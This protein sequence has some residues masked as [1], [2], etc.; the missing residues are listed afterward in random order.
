MTTTPSALPGPARAKLEA[1]QAASATPPGDGTTPP[2]D[3][4]TPPVAT[5]PGDGTAPPAGERVTISREEFNALQAN[6]AR[7]QTADAR[8]A[9]TQSRL[10]ELTQRL[11][12]LETSGKPPGNATAPAPAAPAA[13]ATP[14]PAKFNVPDTAGIQFTDEENEQYGEGR[15]YIERVA[16]VVVLDELKKLLPDIESHME[17]LRSTATSASQ[18]VASMRV[19][20]FNAALLKAVP[21]V[22]ELIKHAN[23]AA[24]LD[25]VEPLTGFTM[26]QILGANVSKQ[27]VEGMQKVYDTFRTK[28]VK[29]L[30][31]STGWQSGAPD[32]GTTPP[33]LDD[34]PKE[35]L[36]LSDR[37]KASDDY[38]FKRITW[39]QLQEVNKKF[40]EADKQGL[41]DYNA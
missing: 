36:K 22:K 11:T 2:G 8:A 10:E 24:F 1:L 9:D 17:E 21:D 15:S 41:V 35:K 23:W 25:E 4:T 34:K 27:N 39:E 37:R 28:Y 20:S 16:R 19:G 3:G 12:E 7:A 5:P 14:K 38:K 32:G 26:E 13:P 29:P 40:D 30:P 31:N 6:A 18:S 33:P